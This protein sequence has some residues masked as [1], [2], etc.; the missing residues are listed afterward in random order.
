MTR[1]CVPG[2]DRTDVRQFM[3]GYRCPDHTPAAIAGRAEPPH[4]EAMLA[5]PGR[6]TREP[7]RH[8]HVG[9]LRAGACQACGLTAGF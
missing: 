7:C 3:N 9:P 5:Q 2:C 4:G 6:A 8:G 1:E